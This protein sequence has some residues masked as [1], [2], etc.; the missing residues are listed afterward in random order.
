M[1]TITSKPFGT[2]PDGRTIQ[3]WTLKGPGGLELEVLEYGARIHRL[4]VP[5]RAG[6]AEDVVLG[7]ADL[8][9]YLGM[10]YHGAYIGRFTNRLGGA[11]FALGDE[12]FDL[13]TNDGKHNLHGGDAGFHQAVFTVVETVEGDEPSITLAY[14]SP[15]GESRFPGT[16][17]TQVRYT[18]KKPATLEIAYRAVSDKATLYNPTNHAFF[19]LTGGEAKGSILDTV[20][21]IPASRITV[22]DEDLI[23]AG[24]LASV[25]AGTG[26][27]DFRD[28]KPIGRDI[29]ADERL[30]TVCGGYDQNFCVDGEGFRTHAVASDPGSGRCMEVLSDLPGVQL[31]T[32]NFGDDARVGKR[33]VF[34]PPHS[35]FCLETQFWPDAP[36]HPDFAQCTLEPGREFTTRTEYRF[37]TLDKDS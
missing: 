9:G 29:A 12:R 11:S 8:D 13:D 3:S 1:H 10:D 30:I 4:L 7:R 34:Y 24:E 16:L 18:L 27:F 26:A 5:D 33:G 20:L 22:C 15:D 25:G 14:E 31:Y 35:A 19:N 6:L 37:S 21:E 28:P 17:S 36:N 2:L 32:F 23:P